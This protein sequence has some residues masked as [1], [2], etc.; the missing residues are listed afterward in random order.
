MSELEGEGGDDGAKVAPVIEITRTEETR[1]ELPVRETR[2]GE[3]LGDSGF[4]GSGES[5][6]PEDPF[7]FFVVQPAFDLE[8]DIPPS[9]LHASLSIPT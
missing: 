3:R 7:I 1:S 6:E 2:L 4:P 5:V 9:S 8:E